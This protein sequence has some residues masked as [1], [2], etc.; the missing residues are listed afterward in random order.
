MKYFSTLIVFAIVFA[1]LSVAYADVA[2]PPRPPH[3]IHRPHP[4]PPPQ[5]KVSQTQFVTVKV[6]NFGKL[7]LRFTFPADCNYKYQLFDKESGEKIKSGKFSYRTGKTV[8]R[9][10]DLNERLTDGK[11]SFLLKIQMSSITEQTRFGK[12]IWRDKVKVAKELVIRKNN[13]DQKYN[14]RVH[15]VPAD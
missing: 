13:Q 9:V 5:H 10:V 1:S 6:D 11:N 7:V 4:T 15:D 14:V 2:R 12:K 3:P 8:E